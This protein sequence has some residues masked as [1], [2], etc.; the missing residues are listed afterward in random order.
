MTNDQV[1]FDL[2]WIFSKTQ[3][4]YASWSKHKTSIEDM[5]TFVILADR[6]I[7]TEE[8]LKV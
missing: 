2:D 4:S 7:P 5:V 3:K 8:I 1:G 6:M